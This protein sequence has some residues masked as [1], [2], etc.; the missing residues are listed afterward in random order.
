MPSD[1]VQESFP[2]RSRAKYATRSVP[3][4]V[5]QAARV[6]KIAAI[7]EAA[8]AEPEKFGK[9]MDDMDRTGRVNGVYR[10]L[11][12]TQQAEL[13]RAEPPPLPNRGP[14]RVGTVD[15]PWPFEPDDPDPAASR[16]VAVP[17]DVHRLQFARSTSTPS[18]TRTRSS[19]SGRRTST[20]AS[21]T[22]SLTLGVR[23]SADHLDVGIRIEWAMATGY[24]ARPSTRS[25]DSRKAY[26]HAHQSDDD[27]VRAGAGPLGQARE[28]Y[29][30]VENLCPARVC[31]SLL[32]LSAQR[33]VGLPRR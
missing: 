15:V 30:L 2:N 33:T 12:N 3:S 28:F 5:C 26:C 21:P 22:R 18:C 27:A 17:D 23:R 13:I 20:C 6:Q 8:E 19:G 29:D 11:K 32:A 16:R 7:V 24:A 14:Y 31:R 4:L 10:R 9:L 1:A 25:G